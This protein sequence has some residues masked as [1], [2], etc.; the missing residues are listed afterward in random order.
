MAGLGDTLAELAARARD[1]AATG[2]R[3]GSPKVS[4]RSVPHFGANPGA[5]RMWLYRPDGLPPGAPLV[6][7]LH[8]CGQTAAGYGTGAGWL[9]LADRHGFAVICP[10][11]VRINNA[12]LCFNW[13]E[14]ADTGRGQGEAAS[15]AQMIRHTVADIELDPRRVFV[16]GLSA[17]G[18]MA[19]VMLATYPEL[20]AAGAIIAGLPYGAASG[21]SQ[22]LRAMRRVPELSGKVWGNKVRAAAPPPKRWPSI[23]IWHGDAD[24]TVDPAAAQALALQWCDV[25]EA[26]QSFENPPASARHKK[27]SW[28][29]ADGSIRVELHRV[30]GL[31]HGTPI[32]ANGDDGCGSPAP[33][34]LEAGLSSSRE[35][36][37]SWGLLGAQ[38]PRSSGNASRSK[39]NSCEELPEKPSPP[40]ANAGETIARALRKAGLM[41]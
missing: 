18:A 14:D 24:T 22:A 36:S 30:S 13:F 12:N 21:M 19:A 1:S 33:W 4:L 6:V 15:I 31:G 32:A 8:G 20:F 28:L 9:E 41:R 34:I 35:I 10:E 39:N 5:L 25:H 7:V 40:L 11:Q 3:I 27:V 16:T 38:R 26:W 17:G 37:R 23:A 29:R 2:A